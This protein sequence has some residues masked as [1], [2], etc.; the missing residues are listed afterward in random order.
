VVEWAIPLAALVVSCSTLIFGVI[1]AASH[2]NGKHVE[3]IET[4][5]TSLERKLELCETDRARL[6][7]DNFR[8]MQDLFAKKGRG[9]K[10][11]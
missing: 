8:L 1:Q 11:V 5:V 7:A 6:K 4:R 2:A 3:T 10:E 9:T